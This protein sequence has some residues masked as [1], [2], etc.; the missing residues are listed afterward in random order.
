MLDST[1]VLSGLGRK[2]DASRAWEGIECEMDPYG[3]LATIFKYSE[4]IISSGSRWDLAQKRV[5]PPP[6]FQ[7]YCENHF[8]QECLV[9]Y[10]IETEKINRGDVHIQGMADELRKRTHAG[11]SPTRIQPDRRAKT[12][13][14]DKTVPKEVREAKMQLETLR[15]ERDLILSWELFCAQLQDE[16]SRVKSTLYANR[17]SNDGM[18]AKAQG[19]E[20][21]IIDDRL[22]GPGL[23]SGHQNCPFG[24]S[25]GMECRYCQHRPTDWRRQDPVS[26][27]RIAPTAPMHLIETCNIGAGQV[28]QFGK[29][30]FSVD[31]CGD[32]AMIILLSMPVLAEDQLWKEI[33][34]KKPEWSDNRIGERQR[35]HKDPR[36]KEKLRFAR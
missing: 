26:H 20:R 18:Y 1:K 15:V 23:N 32:Q 16:I 27:T 24:N 35:R 31:I 5:W 14:A 19:S 21:R 12:A 28:A 3:A 7:A 29:I 25:I 6:T 10:S 2:E 30:Q 4:T 13:A 9:Y 33:C 17:R 36:G 22:E 8:I 34:Q 11:A